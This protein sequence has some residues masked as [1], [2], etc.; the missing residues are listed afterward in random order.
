MAT[1]WWVTIV[2]YIIALATMSTGARYFSL[3]L[4][5][6]GVSGMYD[7]QHVSVEVLKYTKIA[8]ALLL[9]WV[10]NTIPRPPA[11]RSVAMGLVNGVGNL[12]NLCVCHLVSQRV[13][14]LDDANWTPSGWGRTYG[15]LAGVQSTTSRLSSCF[16]VWCSRAS[17]VWVSSPSLVSLS[18]S[19]ARSRVCA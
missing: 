11:K 2:G 6:A 17:W 19:N 7:V 14:S 4:M 18:R 12:G 3:F 10:S 1:W 5:A 9:N 16:A 15:K 13:A 8:Y